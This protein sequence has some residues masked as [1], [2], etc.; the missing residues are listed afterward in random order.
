MENSKPFHIVLVEP[1][2]PPNTGNIARLCGATGTTLH[3][4][5]KLGFSTDDKHLKRAGLDYWSEVEIHYWPDL[6]TLQNAYS[7]ARF[8][9]TSK[10]VK[11]SYLTFKFQPGDFILFGKET[12]G[13]SEALIKTN[14]DTSIRIPMIN[15]AVR[16][17]NLATAAGIVLYEALRQTGALDNR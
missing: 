3:L 4:V 1:E 14:P 8:V 12:K 6:E 9:Y 17:L 11:P 13:L 2:I 15:K 10:K 5:G 7:S 16:S